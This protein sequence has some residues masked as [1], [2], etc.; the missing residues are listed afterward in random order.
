MTHDTPRKPSPRRS[1]R[2]I[3]L[4][5]V[6]S[7]LAVLGIMGVAFAFSMYLETQATRQFVST[8]QARYIAEAGVSYARALLD[9]D[10]LGSRVDDLTEAWST[11]TRGAEA[12]AD[13]DGTPESAWE[14]MRTAAGAVLGRFGVAVRDESGKANLNAAVAQPSPLELGA[15]NLTTLLEQAGLEDA[16]GAAAA[17]ERF[18]YGV[19]ERPGEGGVDDDGDGA[20][21]ELDE[22]QPLALRGDDR[23]LESLEELTR[24]AGLSSDDL[25]RLAQVATVYTW[26]LNI[27]VAGGARVNVNTAT[28]D[29][30]LTVLLEAGVEDPW[31]AAVNMADFSD[32]DLEV[33][34][35]TKSAQLLLASNEG[36][37][38][39]WEWENDPVG[40]YASDGPSSASLIWDTAITPGTYRVRVWGRP[41]MLVGDVTIEGSTKPSVDHGQSMG[42]FELDGMLSVQITN[43]EAA[44][45]ACAF[46]GIELVSESTAAG[47]VPVR[48]V[49]AVRFN[50]LMIEPVIELSIGSATFDAQGSDWGCPPGAE[51]C[52]SSGVGSARW[53]WTSPLLQPGRYYVRAYGTAAGQTVG[54]MRIDGAEQLLVHGQT[55]EAT[56]IVGSDGKITL[57]LGKTA[58]EETYYFKGVALSLQPDAEY[59]ELINLSD[60]EIDVGGWTIEGELTGGRQARLPSGAV[61]PAHGL[62]VAAV[63]LD[64]GQL[65][66]EGN[67]IDARAA[68]AI[69]D[70]PAVQLEFP[71][72][73]PSADD[74]WLKISPGAGGVTRLILRSGASVVDEVEYPLPL[75]TTANFQS[76]EKGDP[77]VNL[78]SDG[79]GIDDGWFPSL[80]LYTPGVTNDNNG[81]RELNGLEVI[82]H[83]PAGEVAV[84]N[85]PLRGVGELAGLASG[86]PWEPFS[87]EDLAK[88]VDRLTV[89]GLVLE[90][91]GRLESGGDA[92]LEHA[93]G[94]YEY[95]STQ[96]PAAVGRWRWTQVP[97]GRYRLGLFGWSGESMSVRWEQADGAYSA[98]SPPL[99]ADAR[100]ALVVGE[101]TIGP[102]ASGE[103]GAPV[104]PPNTLALEARCA[105]ASG[106]CHLGHVQLDPQLIR[107]GPVNIN[108]APLE[109]LR[110]LPDMTEPLASRLIAGRPYGD[111]DQKGRGIGDVL[112]GDVLGAD[113]ETKLAVF[114]RLAH[115]LTTRSD[116]F[117]IQSV[118][119]ATNEDDRVNASQRITTVV[120]R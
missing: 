4:L 97:E 95:S 73:P 96:Q 41:G 20:I 102:A 53:S 87:S 99:T 50:E 58:A 45:T 19:D 109:V 83:D 114:R 103:T 110:A 13:N 59:V 18:R 113:E 66:L 33:S 22:Y 40:H 88:L 119:Q 65:T 118:G 68:W 100:G 30:L 111:R 91:E 27:A 89:E 7:L 25:R 2:G 120:Q 75:P 70:A 77:T 105:S 92:W 79:D 46:R 52:V 12:D 42:V 62:L 1:E 6:V 9:E 36:P 39:A 37:L 69:G 81:L 24:L 8:T 90:V 28:P 67:G 43:R 107:V 3:A 31:Q 17:I 60:N 80:R 32:A 64:D 72:G 71:G 112:L 84:L 117:Q 93:E 51:A 63:D 16:A 15:I 38:G 29:E 115:L 11:A 47:G 98:W 10:R 23:L 49:E 86:E 61:I 21:D 48:G 56:A 35:V 108:T 78:D 14:P 85:R 106:I 5:I 34:R 116:M 26:D 54:L 101:I 55:H 104:T 94:Y 57:T 76:L 44:G 74:D 82:T